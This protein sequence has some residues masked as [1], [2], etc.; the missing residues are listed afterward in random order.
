MWPEQR[1]RGAVPETGGPALPEVA[2][3]YSMSTAHRKGT[4]VGM[5][6]LGERRGVKAG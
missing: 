4:A 6:P 3:E 5:S 1:L 2:N